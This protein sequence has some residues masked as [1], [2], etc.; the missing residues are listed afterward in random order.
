MEM[1]IQGE[2]SMEMISDYISSI[3]FCRFDTYGIGLLKFGGFFLK[4]HF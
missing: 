1:C 3:L 2:A 4:A